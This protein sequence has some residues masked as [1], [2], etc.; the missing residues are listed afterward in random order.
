MV[1]LNSFTNL[2]NFFLPAVFLL[3]T[4]ILSP[5]GGA[6][7][8][9]IF[10]R[11]IPFRYKATES[12]EETKGTFG[13][14]EDKNVPREWANSNKNPNNGIRALLNEIEAEESRLFP[15]SAADDTP[16]R[17]P[18]PPRR[19]SRLIALLPPS[20]D[21]MVP[22]VATNTEPL[23]REIEQ[24]QQNEAVNSVSGKAEDYDNEAYSNAEVPSPAAAT[25]LHSLAA[26]RPDYALKNVAD[27]FR[28]LFN[29]RIERSQ[30]N[31]A[32]EGGRR[33]GFDDDDND[34]W[35]RS[36]SI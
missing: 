22:N 12:G 35:A 30:K 14:N 7:V 6:F 24:Q 26:L 13:T 2:S 28:N 33:L 27:F 3:G 32:D 5:N 21:G 4:I 19:T 18:L 17:P 29:S 25:L 31:T 9:G 10:Y 36:L 1:L 16:R 34:W 20:A 15:S 8:E 23:V 11:N